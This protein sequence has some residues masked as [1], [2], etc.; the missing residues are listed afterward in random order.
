[1]W[2]ALCV[3]HVVVESAEN[4]PAGWRKL[5][6]KLQ[7]ANFFLILFFMIVVGFFELFGEYDALP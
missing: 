3:V 2:F 6:K 1:M 7:N 4:T 5:N